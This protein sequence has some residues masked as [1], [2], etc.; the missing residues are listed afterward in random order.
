[1]DKLAVGLEFA[2]L[3]IFHLSG[4]IAYAQCVAICPYLDLVK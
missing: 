4:H 2:D 3:M 1:M